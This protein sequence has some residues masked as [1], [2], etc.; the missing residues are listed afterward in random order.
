MQSRFLRKIYKYSFSFFILISLISPTPIRAQSNS[1]FFDTSLHTTLTVSDSGQARVKHE[2]TVTNK[3]PTTYISQ[4]GLKVSSAELSN[5]TAVSNGQD[6][7]PEVV[8]IKNDQQ[9][10]PGQTSIGITFPDQLVGEGKKRSFT[11]SYTHP[12]AAVISGQVLEV[13]LPP[14]ANPQDYTQYQVTLITPANFGG[15]VRTTPDQHTFTANGNQI[16]TS[17]ARGGERGV[18]A[19]FGQEQIF[20]LDINYH[21]ANQSNNPGLAQVALPPDTTWQRVYYESLT[22]HPEKMEVDGDGNWIATYKLSA[23]EKIMVKLLARVKLTLE[24]NL[25]IPVT[26]PT[27]EL[28]LAQEYWPVNNSQIKDLAAQ[29][30]TPQEINDFVVQTLSYD[31]KRALSLPERLGA[32]QALNQPETAVCQEFTDVFVTLAR[33]AQIPARR[34]TG[35]AHSQNSQLRPLS[36]VEDVLH[37]WPE[38]Y[39]ETQNRWLPIDPTWENTTG[40]VDYF[41]QLDLNHIV[42]AINGQNSTSP[43]PAGSYKDETNP[44]KTVQVEFG[45]EF[46]QVKPTIN[47]KLQPQKILGVELPGLYQLQITNQTGVALYQLPIKTDINPDSQIDF[48][49]SSLSEKSSSLETMIPAI[50]PFQTLSLPLQIKHRHKI[51]PAHDTIGV[52]I[53]QQQKKFEITTGP[54]FH[55]YEYFQNNKSSQLNFSRPQL[56]LGSSLVFITLAIGSLLVLR[57]KR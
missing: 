55:L 22:P 18:F 23:G 31:T 3:T 32:I 27:P 34:V 10:G 35:Y 13:S 1:D 54:S 4:Y 39:D 5:V 26:K 20:D 17:F 42:F 29:Y 46:P 53:N 44:Q 28:L 2:F 30:S 12:D 45:N 56:V 50:L 11:I 15:P 14:Q 25:D 16:I 6:L 47:F 43:H 52:S 48:S 24:P 33:A 49:F 37:S 21:L 9:A 57:R 51:F 8:P 36:L 7:K 38:Y 40:G 41:H 19:L